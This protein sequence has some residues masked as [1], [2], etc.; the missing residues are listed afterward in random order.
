MLYEYSLEILSED[1]R[2]L[3]RVGLAPDWQPALAWAQFEGIRE[4]R[5]PAVTGA[6]PGVVEPVW[7]GRAGPPLVAAFRAV[8][9]G[10]GGEEVSRE[11]P[12]T[13]VRDLAHRAA[14]RLT[15][16]GALKVGDTFLYVVNAVAGAAAEEPQ[17]DGFSVEAIAQ[18]LPLIDVP[19]A[20]FRER[21]ILSGPDEPAGQVPVFLRKQILVEAVEQARQAADVETGGV[22]VG[23]LC[24]D[25]RTDGAAPEI[26]LEIT[27][28]VAAPHTR[29][30]ST[31]LTFTAETWAAVQA[32]ITLR[33]RNE[34]MLGWWH[35]HPDFCRL[36]SCPVER[37]AQCP[38]SSAFFSE[39][40]VHLHATCFPA[41][42]HV[43][44]LIN[45]STAAGGMTW[46]IFG[47][48]RGM[49]AARGFHVLTDDTKGESHATRATPGS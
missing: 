43:A 29:A 16:K 20:P 32:A 45:E 48:S 30:Q 2:Q 23:K 49:V 14:A 21:S 34:L 5:L 37:R 28:Q 40:D 27:A 8:V 31:R 26:F 38:V 22:L 3:D 4:G 33:R 10:E 19:I 24:R 41:A 11:I 42:Y 39:E 18:P 9:R 47:W 17:P 12:R 46:S 6:V 44:L 25:R 36:R 15:E 7:D 13:Y 1:G 35:F